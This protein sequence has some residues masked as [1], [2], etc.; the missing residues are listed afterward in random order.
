M[1]WNGLQIILAVS[2]CR[3]I[4]MLSLLDVW[5]LLHLSQ[6]STHFSPI[7][8]SAT[9]FSVII[10]GLLAATIGRPYLLFFYNCFLK[11]HAKPGATGTQQDA[12][13]S[14]Y[15]GQAAVYDA[16]RGTLLQGRIEMLKLAAAQLKFKAEQEKRDGTKRERGWIWV[17][18]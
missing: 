8:I 14:F 2:F 3:F 16:T 7:V 18:V 13:E 17:D 11:P 9:A 5:G 12:L 6:E 10:F 15:Q 4:E 1:S